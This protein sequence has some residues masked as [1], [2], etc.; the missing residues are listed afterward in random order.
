MRE[1]SQ[2][3]VRGLSSD[4]QSGGKSLCHQALAGASNSVCTASTR[5]QIDATTFT[6]AYLESVDS[7]GTD[8]VPV[9]DV[10]ARM[11]GGIEPEALVLWLVSKGSAVLDIGLTG[12]TADSALVR[13]RLHSDAKDLAGTALV[14]AALCV[15]WVLLV[16]LLGA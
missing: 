16:G 6:D 10:A 14:T 12:M 7:L 11:P 9:R 8:L 15:V 1:P 3:D 2:R 5:V 13:L 4:Q